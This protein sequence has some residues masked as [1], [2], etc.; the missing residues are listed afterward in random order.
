MA[1]SHLK[2]QQLFKATNKEIKATD[3]RL[4]V[5]HMKKTRVV[6]SGL[7]ATVLVSTT[8]LTV[9]ATELTDTQV[10]S[11][12]QVQDET[13]QGQTDADKDIL[14]QQ[15]ENTSLNDQ[16]SDVYKKAYQDQWL[17]DQD[18]L[19]ESNDAGYKVGLKNAPKDK[20]NL[21]DIY[22]LGYDQGYQKG[23]K[24][25]EAQHPKAS[26]PNTNTAGSNSGR[27]SKENVTASSDNNNSTAATNP[28]SDAGVTNNNGSTNTSNESPKITSLG[29]GFVIP[30]HAAFIQKFATDAQ[31]VAYSHN[32]YAS[33]MIAQAALES[34]WGSSRLSAAPNYNLFGIKGGFKGQSVSMM[35]K[36][37]NGNGGLFPMLSDFRRYNSY[38]DS[39]TDYASVLA[40][41]NFTGVLKSNAPTYQA[42][43]KALTGSYAT[44]TSYNLKL[45]QIIETYDLTKYDA[46]PGQTNDTPNNKKNTSDK[47]NKAKKTPKTKSS[48]KDL[49]NEAKKAALKSS[50]NGAVSSSIIGLPIGVVVI[51]IGAWLTKKK[52]H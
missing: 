8:P 23:L 7:M 39:L 10:S 50:A 41:S 18:T 24:E 19:K 49:M 44:D 11:E 27:N 52:I 5:H 12:L 2:K 17:K 26:V 31:S 45:N 29:P 37:D 22:Q 9:L 35:T 25:Y 13:K 14:N 38:T 15:P 6:A 4:T 47:T 32:L 16:G 51:S 21:G 28:V 33:V 36:E 42:A 48:F 1:T 46:K 3:H 40:Q 43:T 34:S 20:L 30:S